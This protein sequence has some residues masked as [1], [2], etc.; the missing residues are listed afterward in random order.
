[1]APTNIRVTEQE[2]GE[3][4]SRCTQSRHL[5]A[6]ASWGISS[7]PVRQLLLTSQLFLDLLKLLLSWSSQYSLVHAWMRVPL[8]STHNSPL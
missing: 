3:I 1:M 8:G 2:V 4:Y 5:G 6:K 7:L